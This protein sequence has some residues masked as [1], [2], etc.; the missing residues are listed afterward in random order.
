MASHS[1][2]NRQT[3]LGLDLGTTSVGW[4]LLEGFPKPERIVASGVRIFPEGMDRTKGEKSL[5]QDRRDARSLRRLGCRRVRRKEKLK[6]ALQSA[7]LLPAEPTKLEELLRV[8]HPYELRARALDEKLEPWQVGRAL[9]H[10]GQRR[11]YLSNRKSGEEKDGAVAAGIGELS[12]AMSDAGS[13][14]LGEYFAGLDPHERRIRARYT[15]REM[16]LD[17]FEAI[18]EA[19]AP[20]HPKAMGALTKK[21]VS[22]AIF[23]QRPLKVQRHLIGEC[24]FE[25]GRKRAPKASLAAQEFRLWETINRIKVLHGDGGERWLT[26]KER[27]TLH[28]ALATKRTLSWER[29]RKL[30]GL[31]EHDRF[32]LERVRKSGLLGNHTA[33]LLHS[34][35]KAK[36]W[37]ALGDRGREELVHD[38]THLD[39]EALKRRLT[40]HWNF[41]P[42][43][44]EALFDKAR[45]LPKGHLHLSQKAAREITRHLAFAATEHDR[46]LSYDQACDKAGYIHTKPMEE[47]NFNRLPFPGREAKPNE[48]RRNKEQR[49]PAHDEATLTNQITTDG[50]R[51]PLVERALFQVRRVVNAVIQ[52]YGKPDI[53]RVE[54]ARDLKQ[55]AK[56]REDT[57]KRIRKNEKA[58]QEAEKFLREE[59]GFDN[60]SR[61]DL[62]KYRLWEE[63][64]HQCPFSGKSI[65]PHA[66]FK[67]PEFHIEHIVPYSRSLD[68]SYMNKT[69]CHN[70]WNA[71]KGNQTPWEAFHNDESVY[72]QILQRA[73]GL[74][75]PKFKRFSEAAV[76]DLEKRDFVSQQLNETR[77]IAR[78]ATEYLSQLG[79]PVEPVKGGTTAWLRR[80]WGLEN[81]FT[82]SPVK[83]REDHRHHAV[84]ALVTALTDRKAVHNITRHAQAGLDGKIRILDYPAPI[85]DLRKK[86]EAA[87]SE[88]I[89]SHKPQRKIKGP[90]HE[91]TLYGL[92]RDPAGE[93]IRDAK[94]NLQV[95]LRKRLSEM[96]PKDLE[97]IRDPIVREKAIEHLDAHGGDPKR[98]FGKE[99][100]DFGFHAKDGRFIAIRKVVIQ[101]PLNVAEIGNGKRRRAVKTGNNHRMEYFISPQG[102]W[103][104]RGVSMLEATLERAAP[105][106]RDEHP[107]LVLHRN[108]LLRIYLN[109][110]DR[111]RLGT[112]DDPQ[113]C[114]VKQIDPASNRVILRLH[115]DANIDDR[116]RD[117]YGSL[118]NLKNGECELLEIDVL[119]SVKT[120][121]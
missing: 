30:L 33:A 18:W 102:K 78:K 88:I 104:C 46:G 108:D 37:K 26:D 40:R 19:Q 91:A 9:Y 118:S 68:D 69:L 44:A 15:A 96:K 63:C 71:R 95:T 113:V 57:Q 41:E 29:I 56:Q 66:L 36:A 120:R 60:P 1:P 22:D 27:L 6:H 61:T 50:L 82:D 86:A 106:P 117:I 73:K 14:T 53:I 10:L 75:Y 42:E 77:Y 114:R 81:L 23:H 72:E 32:N 45:Q 31:L 109:P 25:P 94:G 54:M 3:I 79:V 115:N 47:R 17:E 38:L 21:A 11:G 116:G 74:P 5:N 100:T 76:R 55:N 92:V 70:E 51:N 84:D 43:L 83:T 65:T 64:R 80:A 49:H 48:R 2:K 35:L 12:Q 112:N 111:K 99:P 119:G 58:N 52:R 39:D 34:I 85:R 89:V 110:K 97:Q 101:Y 121:K 59:L 28:D 62:I 24:E 93:P 20:H 4:C 107:F 7:G 103:S 87:I 67:E 90:L 16:Y 98:A 8:T 105:T 13:R